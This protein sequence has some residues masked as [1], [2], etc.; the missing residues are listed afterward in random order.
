MDTRKLQEVVADLQ[1]QLE[2]QRSETKNLLEENNQLREQLV[3][4]L[5]N[6]YAPK[7]E[8]FS[9]KDLQFDE[10]DISEEEKKIV[11]EGDEEINIAAH[12]R[13]KPKRKPLPKD[14]PRTIVEHRLPEDQMRCDCGCLLHVIGEDRSEQLEYTPPQLRVLEHIR[15]KY[16][17]RQCEEGVKHAP[18]PKY[19]IPKSIATSSLLANIL[20][21][22]YCDALPLYRQE[23]MWRRL[24]ID[25]PRA[26]LS[27]W[28]L[29]C[30]ELF[31]PLIH[32]MQQ[33]II[34]GKKV[35]ADETPVQV[36]KEPEKK[37]T[38]KSYMW[39]FVG[40]PES[41][42]I[43]YKYH[44][45]RGGI[46]ATEFMEGFK[47]YLQADGYSGYNEICR[48]EGVIRVGCWMHARRKFAD[49]VK[50]TKKTGK[51]H[52][53]MN[54]IRKLYKIEEQAKE[55]NLS[56]EQI[57]NLRE[58]EAQPILEEFKQWL[59]DSQEHVPPKGLLG[60]AITYS[61]SNWPEL[62]VYL[63]DGDL[64]IDNGVAERKLKPFVIGRK[65][66]LFMG[67]VNGANAGATIYSLIE[68]SKANGINPYSYLKYI[69][70]KLPYCNVDQE[71][72]KLLPW[73]VD[74]KDIAKVAFKKLE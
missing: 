5:Y 32:L 51:A 25:L 26:T 47:G 9:K 70:E 22:K 41:N 27:S 66:W 42:I 69:L 13:K 54:Y 55:R 38:S 37:N 72:E 59:E 29:K 46:V 40:G 6:M 58:E 4:L 63:T 73:N 68:T 12:S 3:L 44:A 31:L 53:A 33:E 50:I 11:E 21:S 1:Q 18:L 39:I 19:P 74:V 15:Y 20:I 35:N 17:C 10:A 23:G 36:M 28:V 30:G 71:R 57:K 8:K 62:T 48:K 67:S 52:V 14:L 64:E 56:A 65:N 43:V 24:G 61:L 16:G 60:K 34:T 49:I 7:S 45:T 2:S